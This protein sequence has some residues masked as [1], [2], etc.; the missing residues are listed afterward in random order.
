MKRHD[1]P[2]EQENIIVVAA[3]TV[4][5]AVCLVEACEYCNPMGAGIPF[6]WM[7][8]RVTGCDSTTTDYIIEAPAKCPN[9]RRSIF[10]KTLIEPMD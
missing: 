9:C 3:A 7:L 10:E 5:Q 6:D 4:R 1:V 8:D 2:P